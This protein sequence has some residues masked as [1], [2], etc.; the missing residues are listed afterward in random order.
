MPALIAVDAG[1]TGI[2][3]FAIDGEGRP[4][5]FAYRELTQYFPRPGWVEHDAAEIR[6][7]VQSTLGELVGRLAGEGVPVAAV[8]ITNQRETVVAWDRRTGQPLHRALVWQD[9]RTADRCD[10]LRE[11]GH[12][13]AIR[14]ATGLVLDPYFSATKMEWLLGEGGVDGANPDLAVGTVD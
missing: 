8:G 7:A 12:E 9:R 10:A 5:G 1:T 6:S 11:A 2:R 13:P 3:A 14:E 4:C